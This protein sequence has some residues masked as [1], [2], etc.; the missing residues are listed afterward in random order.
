MCG[1]WHASDVRSVF[2]M[3]R[4]EMLQYRHLDLVK[5]LSDTPEENLRVKACE[6]S[7]LFTPS[8]SGLAHC[9]R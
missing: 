9:L 7:V 2:K 1:T 5:P 8:T 6:M 3:M 4:T